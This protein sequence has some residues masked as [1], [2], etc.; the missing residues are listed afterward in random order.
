MSCYRPGLASACTLAV[1]LV[2]TGTAAGFV[3]T[4]GSPGHETGAGVCQTADGSFVMIGSQGAD[5]RGP[6]SLY[7]VAADSFGRE[8]WS[9]AFGQPGASI[10]GRAVLAL[11]DGGLLALGRRRVYPATAANDWDIH[12]LALSADGQERWSQT[13]DLAGQDL[14]AAIA[15]DAQG[16]ILV[17]GTTWP[18]AGEGS[19]GFLVALS[20]DGRPL[21]QRIFHRGLL[22]QISGLAIAPAG[23]LLLAG[24]TGPDL[25]LPSDLWLVAFGPDGTL[26]WQRTHDL[27]G[28]DE[29]L[30]V[31]ALAGG[32]WVLTGRTDAGQPCSSQLLLAA[33]DADGGLRWSTLHGGAGFDAGTALWPAAGGGFLVAGYSFTDT[34]GQGGYDLYL[35]HAG[36]A[37]GEVWSYLAGGA[38]ADYGWAVQETADGGVIAAG[39][40][41]S[42]GAGG[43]DLLAVRTDFAGHP[44]LTGSCPTADPG[45]D[46]TAWV[47]ETILLSGSASQDPDNDLPLAFAW[48]LMDRPAGSL[49]S[50][51]TPQAATTT[52]TPD[53]PGAYRLQLAVRDSRGFAGAPAPLLIQALP[54]P[55]DDNDGVRRCEG[56]CDDAQPAVHP[57]A[58]EACDGRDND[59]NGA[60]DE[61]LGTISCGLGACQHTVPACQAGRLAVCQPLPPGAEICGDGVDSDCDG[62]NDAADPDCRLPGLV[63]ELAALKAAILGFPAAWLKNGKDSFKTPLANKLDEVMRLLTAA[64]AAGPGEAPALLAQAAGQ[65]RQDLRAKTDGCYGGHEANDWLIACQARSPGAG[66]IGQDLVLPVLDRVLARLPSPVNP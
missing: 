5:P 51:P 15:L 19:D 65:L 40:T 1:A 66:P 31:A 39:S 32:G 12:L 25:A 60:T 48:Q 23:D 44:G 28:R 43:D 24:T 11:A 41:A 56:D 17:A 52:F 26:S 36:Q 58:A 30:A 3:Q 64:Q 13:V 50:L 14:A 35:L 10:E 61:G 62:L 47:G 54:C 63:A 16:R 6:Q 59:C 2:L 18:R 55:D 7:L 33:L 8:L 42:L 37:G 29:A 45:P 27:F 46:R 4:F 22:D 53:Q 49:A 38:R 9:R 20:P 34:A 21:W 57:G